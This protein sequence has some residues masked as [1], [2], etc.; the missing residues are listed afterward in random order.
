MAARLLVIEPLGA[1]G[2]VVRVQAPFVPAEVENGHGRLPLRFRLRHRRQQGR[3]EM[4]GGVGSG[5]MGCDD[6]VYIDLPSGEALQ[7]IR[8]ARWVSVFRCRPRLVHLPW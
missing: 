4:E 7:Q 6:V 8:S 1:D 2:E 5:A 3:V